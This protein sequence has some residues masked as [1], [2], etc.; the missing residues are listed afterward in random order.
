M[1][2]MRVE[3]LFGLFVGTSFFDNVILEL[4]NIKMKGCNFAV[5]VE[6][7]FPAGLL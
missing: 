4:W 3:D 7:N 6:P 1:Y 5:P 2:S